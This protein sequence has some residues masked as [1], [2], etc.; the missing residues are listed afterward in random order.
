MDKY[1]E[2]Y[3]ESFKSQRFGGWLFVIL[4][5]LVTIIVWIFGAKDLWPLRSKIILTIVG[6]FIVYAF[7]YI[8]IKLANKELKD[9]GKK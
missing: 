4:I 8:K 6:G 5:T 7:G 2:H 1:K 9:I 3:I